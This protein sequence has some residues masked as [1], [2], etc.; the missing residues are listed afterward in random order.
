MLHAVR[1]ITRKYFLAGLLALIPLFL[2][3]WVLLSLMKLSDHFLELIPRAYRPEELLGRQIPGLGLLLTVIMVFLIG[4]LAANV[5]GRSLMS[6]GERVLKNIPLLRWFYF[7]TKQLLETIFLKGEDSFRRSILLEYPRK[8][9][10]SLGFV[11]GEAR[12]QMDS[13]VPGRALTVFIPT[14]P[15]P[16]S[17]YLVMVPEREVIP[18]SWTVDEAFRFIISAGVLTP[19]EDPGKGEPG[20]GCGPEPVRESMPEG[21]GP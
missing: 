19:V 1:R 4:A 16:T 11:T 9:I 7:S 17:G 12:G 21:E 2:T 13:N 3:G 18:I 8:G 14:T 20:N 5:I 10:Y 15:N 6:Y